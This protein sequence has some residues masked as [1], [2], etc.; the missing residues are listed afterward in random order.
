MTR[1]HQELASGRWR[2]LSFLDQMANIGSEVERYLN[3]RAKGRRD[4]AQKAFDRA[5]ELIDLTLDSHRDY[6]R[7]REVAR[8]REVLADFDSDSPSFQVS[9]DSWRK[10]FWQFGY[11]ARNSGTAPV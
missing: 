6:A 4:Y 9:E 1:Q 7:L 2:Q 8:I 11:A 3:W 5:L 10:Y